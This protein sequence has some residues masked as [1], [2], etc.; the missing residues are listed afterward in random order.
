[1]QTIPITS[2]RNAASHCGGIFSRVRGQALILALVTMSALVLGVIVLFN[3][4][5]VLDKKV[6]L[7]NAADATAY[8]VAVQQARAYNMI[9]YMNRASVANE[10]AM[11]QMVSWYSWT[12]YMLSAT[13]H[14]KDAVQVVAFALD[15][16]VVLA[17]IG[18]ALQQV[19]T[20]LNGVKRAVR[21]AR[22]GLQPAFSLAATGISFIDG[23][24]SNAS[25][26]IGA[27]GSAEA[28]PLAQKLVKQNTGDKAQIGLKGIGVLA[29]GSAEAFSYAKRY[30]IPESGRRSADADRYANVVM[31][32]RDGFSLKRSGGF[33]LNAKPVVEFSIKKRGG[34]DLVDY[35]DWVGADTLNFEAKLG[36][37]PIAGW[38]KKANVAVAWGG[39]AAVDATLRRESFRRVSGRARTWNSPYET[40]RGRHSRY[41]G[42]IDN[43]KAGNKVRRDPA[44]GG[45]RFAWLR[46]SIPREVSSVGSSVGL[47]DYNDTANNRAT[48][49][50]LN[51]KSA[52]ANGVK[53]LDVGPVFTVLVEQPINTVRTSN[54]IEGLGGEGELQAADRA[55]GDAITA[56]ASAQV[57]FSR[58]RDLFTSVVDSRREIGNLFSPYWQARLV[59]TPCATR[60][61][62]ALFSGAIA[63][64]LP[65]RG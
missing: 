15:A 51:G 52:A 20:V 33:E 43:G 11:A 12:N 42:G 53:A 41:D 8:S 29:K 38:S 64:C 37:V 39:G 48:V 46:S 34:T 56:M 10:V 59:E 21:V 17:E 3:T 1:M 47:N 22:D 62:V 7:V 9:A 25:K 5:Q 6:E 13:D 55:V 63:P 35:R 4:G 32:A 2:Y 60:Q 31:A 45:E 26:I 44:P 57:Y 18:V 30:K 23:V 61:Q 16:T 24:Y 14:F 50:Y 65:G 49:P 58:P 54:Q 28:V 27:V 40:G 19:V 36:W